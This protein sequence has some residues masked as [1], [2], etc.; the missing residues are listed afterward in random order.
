M[1]VQIT[2]IQPNCQVLRVQKTLAPHIYLCLLAPIE[3]QRAIFAPE[4]S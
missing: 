4:I 2:A 1:A 3:K